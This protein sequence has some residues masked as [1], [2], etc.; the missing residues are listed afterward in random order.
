MAP[1]G[2]G[3]SK[4]RSQRAGLIFPVGRI[5][6]KLHDGRYGAR[7]GSGAPVFLAAVLEYIVAEVFEL[8]GNACEEDK[9]L[10]ITP[11]HIYLAVKTDEELSKLFKNVTIPST[12]VQSY[13]H[14]ALLPKGKGKSTKAEAGDDEDEEETQEM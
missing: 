3:K 7:I 6:R 8:A 13:I 4:S 1:K 5:D 12:G 9:K 14:P 2:D 11:R 10:R